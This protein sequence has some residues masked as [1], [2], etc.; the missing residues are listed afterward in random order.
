MSLSFWNFKACLQCHTS[1]SKDTPSKS[2]QTAPLTVDQV[3][4]LWRTFSFKPPQML[5]YESCSH[6]LSHSCQKLT[7]SFK[8]TKLCLF[9][10]EIFLLMIVK[11]MSPLYLFSFFFLMQIHL[12]ALCIF[13]ISYHFHHCSHLKIL[14]LSFLHFFYR[15]SKTPFRKETLFFFFYLFSRN[16]ILLVILFWLFKSHIHVVHNSSQPL[17]SIFYL[18]FNFYCISVFI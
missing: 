3:S 1:S 2:T 9:I 17:I 10:P 12:L 15:S 6:S 16:H 11:V 7:T 13:G 5:S 8:F 14:V 4:S 18:I